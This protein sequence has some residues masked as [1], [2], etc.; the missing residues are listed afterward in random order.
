MTGT[1]VIGYIPDSYEPQYITQEKYMEL[2]HDCEY[3]TINYIE[4]E[5]ENHVEEV[6]CDE[7]LLEL[8]IIRED[9]HILDRILKYM[10]NEGY[11]LTLYLLAQYCKKDKHRE[12]LYDF[13][14]YHINGY[15]YIPMKFLKYDTIITDYINA[16][17]N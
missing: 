8:I 9:Y 14:E 2:V 13:S 15:E 6:K 1:A 11:V 5:P 10:G 3:D 17:S 7:R 12:Y 16:H 4:L